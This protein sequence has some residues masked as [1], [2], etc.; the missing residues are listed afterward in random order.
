MEQVNAR[1]RDDLAGA[2]ITLAAIYYCPHRPEDGCDCRKPA[3]GMLLQAVR[4]HG[5]DAGGSWMIGDKCSDVL[6]GARAS[7]RTA[8]VY[9][10]RVCAPA[11]SLRA[12]SF[13]AAVWREPPQ[14]LLLLLAL[15]LGAA[16]ATEANGA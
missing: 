12:A 5:L 8:L 9:S 3:T 14:R 13:S 4:E 1:I 16:G 15:P 11:P 10:D 7:L 2:G 6:G